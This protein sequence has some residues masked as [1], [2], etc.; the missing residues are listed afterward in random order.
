M[1]SECPGCSTTL[2]DQAASCPSCRMALPVKAI[3][4]PRPIRKRLSIPFATILALGFAW[5]LMIGGGKPGHAQPVA[6]S[7]TVGAAVNG[8]QTQIGGPAIAMLESRLGSGNARISPDRGH[9]R[10]STAE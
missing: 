8:R 3:V 2:D 5:A 1:S 10:R 4:A 6:A 9:P 7:E